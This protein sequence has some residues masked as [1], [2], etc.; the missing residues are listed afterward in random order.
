MSVSDILSDDSRIAMINNI[1]NEDEEYKQA[2]KAI[3][4]DVYK[5][6]KDE[7]HQVKIRMDNWI[8]TVKQEMEQD[9]KRAEA[10]DETGVRNQL[11]QQMLKRVRE[12]KDA[13]EKT[14]RTEHR[15]TLKRVKFKLSDVK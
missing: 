7:E 4:N 6:S 2:T 1:V 5:K 9:L 11:Q 15:K 10:F 3:L 14:I 13:N 8:K 12:Y